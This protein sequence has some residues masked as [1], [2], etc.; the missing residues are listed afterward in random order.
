MKIHSGHLTIII[1]FLAL[2][3]AAH[4]HKADII[5]L[6]Q[7]THQF[8]QQGAI[9][10]L[11]VVPNPLKDSSVVEYRSQCVWPQDEPAQNE[12]FVRELIQTDGTARTVTE[13]VWRQTIQV[14]RDIAAI[15]IVDTTGTRWKLISG[16]A[17]KGAELTGRIQR[18]A[19]ETYFIHE[20]ERV[21]FGKWQLVR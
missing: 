18:E 10:D 1:V 12:T 2:L 3:G 7:G 13:P 21:C 5:D 19:G 11:H 9:A 20:D 8:Q 17:T 4:L 15:E 16:E 14:P 6:A